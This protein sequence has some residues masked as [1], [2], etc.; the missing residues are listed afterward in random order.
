V[1]PVETWERSHGAACAPLGG[2][3]RREPERTL[4]HAV[5]RERLEP[6]LA[7][8]RLRFLAARDPKVASRLLD[9]FTR[10]VFA[11]QRR[12][13]R[14][15]GM[16]NPRT[17]GVTAVQRFGGAVNLNVHFHTLF[18]DGVFDL[19]VP[20][21]ARFVPLRPPRDHDVEL[22]LR[23]VIRKVARHGLLGGDE[24]DSADD[25][26]FAALQAAEVDRRLR[27]PD[28][29]K[30][31]RRAAYLDGFSLHAGVGIHANDRDGLERLC[32]YALR[33][34]L[35]LSRLSAGPDGRLVYRIGGR[36]ADRSCSCS[37]PTSSS[38]GSRR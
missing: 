36:G 27:F 4:L 38:R 17:G 14:R 33:P 3:R 2:Y 16:A 34:P 32:R 35:A 11:W 5:V 10:A 31:A 22:I 9:L 23:T 19:S 25:D 37:R 13:A 20:G 18:P 21:P 15:L 6:F 12:S 28:P 29:F 7:A 24:L 8:A 1:D 26:A 30:H